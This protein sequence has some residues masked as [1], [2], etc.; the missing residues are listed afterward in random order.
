[1][2]RKYSVTLPLFLLVIVPLLLLGPGSTRAAD[3]H[4]GAV[5]L[6]GTIPVPTTLNL[7]EEVLQ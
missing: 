3:D 2:L 1:M 4:G 6:L 5:K 7:T